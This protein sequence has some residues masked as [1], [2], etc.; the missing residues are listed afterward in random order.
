VAELVALGSQ[1][2][3]VVRVA[4]GNQR[5]LLAHLDAIGAQTGGLAGIVAEQ[6]NPGEAQAL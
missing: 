6:A 1:I 3:L 4:G 5:N 2:A